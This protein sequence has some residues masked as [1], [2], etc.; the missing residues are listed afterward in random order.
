MKKSTLIATISL[1][2]LD[3]AAL[4]AAGSVAYLIRFAQFFKEARP[5][6]FNLPFEA[7]LAYLLPAAAIGV[8]IFSLFGLYSTKKKNKADFRMIF[9]ASSVLLTLI[10]F[11]FF[12][13][14]ELFS[15]RFIVLAG[16]ILAIFFVFLGRLAFVSIQKSLFKKGIGTQKVILFGSN[17][18]ARDLEMFIN[19]NPEEG[20]EIIGTFDSYKKDWETR[21]SVFMAEHP[22]DL[23]LQTDISLSREDSLR[24]LAISQQ[25]H[26]DFQ[27]VANMFE[28]LGG[29]MNID[30]LF[31][32]PIISIQKTPLEGW[33]TVYKRIY[34]IIV[35]LFAM[36]I[37]SPIF[38]LL[39]VLV[40]L[41]S[42]GPI[43]YKNERVGRKGNTFTT[44]KFRTMRIEYCTGSGYDKTGTALEYEQE[45]IRAQNMRKGGIYKI[46]DDPRRTGLGRFLERTS[47][48]E[49][50]QFF[51]VLLGNM[52]IVG[53]RPHQPREVD[54]YGRIYPKLF[55]VKPGITGLPQI[56]GRSD[57]DTEDE[58]K[59]DLYYIENWSLWQDIAISIKTPF[60]A[61][62]GKHKS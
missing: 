4:L 61:V 21:L 54:H 2:P 53:P 8:G 26:T 60:I 22:A 12:F 51:N 34:D 37:F 3:F 38:L 20:Y 6:I 55:D 25:T 10:V 15:S 16:W 56:S 23:I 36:I 52:S 27:Y 39:A 35:S 1:I 17:S 14:R 9:A 57:L 46:E 31:G 47:L 5:I 40:K 13:S 19:E 28:T 7:Y 32:L 49:L 30:T 24:L 48:D 58:V 50:P 45:L 41:D 59:L 44:Y 42:K 11:L 18:S 29:R 33:G 43:I 62:L